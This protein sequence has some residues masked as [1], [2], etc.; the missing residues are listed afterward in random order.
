MA[1]PAA[2]YITE[3]DFFNFI[4]G[5]YERCELIAG[6]VVMRASRNQRHQDIAANTL[7]A[8][9]TQSLG[10]KCRPTA[11]GTGISTSRGTIRY[12]DVV[13]DCGR[14][15]DQDMLATEPSVIIEV[16]SSSTPC[17]DS[18]RKVLEYKSKPEITYVLLIDARNACVI[19][20]T[21]D[22]EGWSDNIYDTLDEVIELPKIDATLALSEIYNGLE[23]AT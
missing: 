3:E 4:S 11:F 21:R 13:V 14:R 23:A 16:L 17:F 1:H 12:P 18:H 6:E 10:K 22:G 8:L 15:L 5:R 7:T 20:H 2:S 9:H 19:M